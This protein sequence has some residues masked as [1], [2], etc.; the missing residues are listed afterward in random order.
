MMNKKKTKY[1][2]GDIVKV[3]IPR[4]NRENNPV[5]IYHNSEQKVSRAYSGKGKFAGYVELVGA[6]SDK[7][8]PFVFLLD[9]IELI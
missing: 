8:V 6:V 7:G 4:E 2:P 1:Q 5:A 9:W 3:R